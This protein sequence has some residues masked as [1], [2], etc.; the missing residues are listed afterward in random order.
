MEKGCCQ[1]TK[2]FKIMLFGKLIAALLIMLIMWFIYSYQF[3]APKMTSD[4][5]QGFSATFFAAFIVFLIVN[6]FTVVCRHKDKQKFCSRTNCS[7]IWILVLIFAGSIAVG[8]SLA[9]K[10]SS[11][12]KDLT[13]SCKVNFIE[14]DPSSLLSRL[15]EVS[16][17]SQKLLCSSKCPCILSRI[18]TS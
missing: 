1:A 7:F 9:K 15:D 6:T 13:T 14:D 10:R 5:A 2:L 3:F 12:D 4:V 8:W 11:I 17:R 18:V 16:L